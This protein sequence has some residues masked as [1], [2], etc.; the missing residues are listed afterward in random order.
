MRVLLVTPVKEGSGET[1]TALHMAENLTSSGHSVLFLASP[2][3]RS[4]IGSHFPD[5][6]WELGEDGNM[7]RSLWDTAIA[8]FQ[9]EAVVF[10]DYPLMFAP[11]GCSPLV[12]EPGWEESLE[13][14]NACLV[15]LDHFGFAQRE[16]SLYLGPPHLTFYY[17]KFP[18]IPE[19]MH[20]MLP[21]PMN[22]PGP[23]SGRRGEPFRYW[24]VPFSIPE[25]ACREVRARY[26]DHDE[27]FLV[28]HSV[29]NWAWRHADVFELPFYRFLPKI[30]DEYF[31]ALPRRVTIVSVN[32]GSLLEPQPDARVRIIN[33]PPIPKTEFEGLL[34]GSD[35]V[36]T[37][38]K[39][40]I[41]MGKAICGFQP[42][43]VF[44]NSYRLMELTK[45][46][47][48]SLREVVVGMEGI[49]LGS[50]FPYEVYP[51]LVRQDLENIGLYRENS[52]TKG[53]WEL[54]IYGDGETRNVLHRIMTD[55]CF[56]EEL[57]LRQQ[58]YVGTLKGLG[59]S[60]QVL[61]SLVQKERRTH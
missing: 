47:E 6:V 41:S 8:D 49:R 36:I 35:L 50:V 45:Q 37:E 60:A 3:A 22:E 20:I 19:R 54:E 46:L 53:F 48:G 39:V 61:S 30:L 42:C 5:Q 59:D 57:C 17:Y 11:G 34:F 10:A 24:Q 51:S 52:L 33:L 13:E 58:A 23:V 28:F 21:C 56:V 31:G 40:S 27:D 7:N 25:A 4:F 38:N 14:L 12:E 26:L 55:P 16:M 32:N 43:A 15:T 44:K 1:I 29:S 9:P 2:F 18:A